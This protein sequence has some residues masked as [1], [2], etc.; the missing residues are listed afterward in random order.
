M[1]TSIEEKTGSREE[2]RIRPD[3]P[4]RPGRDAGR[5]SGYKRHGT[6]PVIA[7]MNVAAGEIIAS[8]IRRTDSVTFM[9]L[10]LMP[11]QSMAPG[12]RIPLIMGNGSSRTLKATRAWITGLPGF[13]VTYTP[14]HASWLN[15]VPCQNPAQGLTCCFTLGARADPSRLPVHGPGAWLA[16]ALGTQ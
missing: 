1:L 13:S 5:E 3:I 11:G 10:L 4:G 9:S 12:L 15:I 14:E 8:R 7:A 16:G 2:T 6:V